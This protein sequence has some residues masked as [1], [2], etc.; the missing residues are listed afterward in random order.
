[1]CWVWGGRQT[2][3]PNLSVFPKGKQCLGV[4]A[5]LPAS[6][7]SG[8]WAVGIQ[9]LKSSEIQGEGTWGYLDYSSDDV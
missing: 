6:K 8:V 4:E 2:T 3:R 7:Q 5:G 1:M 9:G